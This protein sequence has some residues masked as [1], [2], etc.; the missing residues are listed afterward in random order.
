LRESERGDLID[1]LM[2]YGLSPVQAQIYI[3]LLK[4]G[5]STAKAISI[6]SDINRVDVYRAVKRLSKLGLIEQV[7]GKPIAFMAVDPEQALDI[8][9]GA[10]SNQVE[11]LRS[12]KTYLRSRLEMLALDRPAK[13]ES[14]VEDEEL[15]VKVLSGEQVFRRLKSMLANSKKEVMT[16]FSP[17]SLVLYDRIGVPELEQERVAQGVRIR[18]VTAITRDNFREAITYS[19]IVDLRHLQQLSSHLRYTIVDH[20]LLLLPVADP[21]SNLG[22]ATALWTDSKALIIGLIDDF[23]RLWTNAVPSNDRI[24]RLQAML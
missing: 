22:E 17:K 3:T 2:I 16:I 10:K 24:A 11:R 5:R 4:L 9:V 12:G 23:E 15:F 6:S 18:A 7:L 1:G 14:D 20:S 8:L 21:P 13:N 19:K